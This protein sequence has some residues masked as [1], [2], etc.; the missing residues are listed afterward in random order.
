M[1]PIKFA[2]SVEVLADKIDE[3]YQYLIENNLLSERMRR[4]TAAELNEA[5]WGSI[6]QPILDNLNSEGEMEAM[7]DKLLQKQTNPYSLA[8]EVANRYLK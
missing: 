3:H 5:L 1:E 8:A 6:L 4:K 7:V 2:E